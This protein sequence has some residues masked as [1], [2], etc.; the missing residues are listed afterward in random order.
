MTRL[1]SNTRV[2]RSRAS[3]VVVTA[4]ALTTLAACGGE[5]SNAA[6]GEV[7]TCDAATTGGT[8]NANLPNPPSSLD[9]I[10]GGAGNDHMSLYPIFDRLVNLSVDMA[11]EP[12]LATKWEYPD[13]KTLVLTLQTGVKFHDGTPFNAEAV[14]FNLERARTLPTSTVAANLTSIDSIEA[15]A[16]NTVTIHLSK[17]DTTLPLIFADRAGMMSSPTAIEEK[18]DQQFGLHPVGTGPFEVSNYAPSTSLELTKNENYWQTDMPYLD[19]VKLTYLTDGQTVVNSLQSGQ[20]DA[21]LNVGLQFTETLST[22]SGLAVHTDPSVFGDYLY[23]NANKAPFNNLE[24]RQALRAAIN[25]EALNDTLYLGKGEPATQLFP[26]DYWAYQDGLTDNFYD[27]EAAKDLAES[28]GLA[29]SKITALWYPAA[30]ADRRAQLIQAMLKDVG[31]ELELVSQEVGT[32][33][34]DFFAN[35]NGELYIA[36]WSGRP[37]PADTFKS[38]V[39]P[40]GFYNAGDF[41]PEGHDVDAMIEAGQQSPEVE[42]RAEAYKPLV[43]LIE[44]QA[45]AFPLVFIP[46]T[47]VLSTNVGGFES[48]LYGKVDVSFLCVSE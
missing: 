44:D 38:I 43:E 9:P 31:V 33:T 29:G 3:F 35:K 1:S 47:T 12:G 48:G 14:K 27:P 45:L 41:E 32:A 16:E 5:S 40:G 10:Q 36:G 20:T 19:D 37:D 13:D 22:N 24:A 46:I 11:P 17:P 21:A 28:S 39:S 23:V 2:R 15:T 30:G 34:N 6:A 18:G 8:L 26:T 4:V 42:D 25:T 7:P